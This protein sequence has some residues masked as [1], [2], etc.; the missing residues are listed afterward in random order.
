MDYYSQSPDPKSSVP[1]GETAQTQ[2]QLTLDTLKSA[3]LDGVRRDFQAGILYYEED[4]QSSLY[5]HIR[6]TACSDCLQVHVNAM[7]HREELERLS[8]DIIVC[9]PGLITAVIELKYFPWNDLAVLKQVCFD[10]LAKLIR[11]KSLLGE[12]QHRLRIQ[13][14]DGE[15]VGPEYR[16]ESFTCYGL[17][18]I[19]Q[20]QQAGG[21]DVFRAELAE[22]IVPLRGRF[23]FLWGLAGSP[24]EPGFGVDVIRGEQ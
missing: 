19:A 12:R 5:H 1:N 17:G 11:V 10:D 22:K 8:P 24:E 20:A 21:L 18:V 2:A 15:S 14:S 9:S 7:K 23:L 16:A 3:W 4:L 6:V 13:S